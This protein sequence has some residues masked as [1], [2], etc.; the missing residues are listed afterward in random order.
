[1]ISFFNYWKWHFE[2]IV[3]LTFFRIGKHKRLSTKTNSIFQ[4]RNFDKSSTAPRDCCS[5]LCPP[6]SRPGVNVINFLLRYSLLG[7][8]SLSAC[9]WHAIKTLPIGSWQALAYLPEA[10]V[11]SKKFFWLRHLVSVVSEVWKRVGVKCRDSN[12]VLPLHEQP[13]DAP[14]GDEAAKLGPERTGRVRF[15][16]GSLEVDVD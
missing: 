3:G 15:E 10:T 14:L 4:I 6:A 7:S 2:R 8:I 11:W 13:G 12:R 1:M 5:W 16:R 9:S